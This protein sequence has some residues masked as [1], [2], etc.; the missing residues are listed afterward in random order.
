MTI[1]RKRKWEL[2]YLHARFK[3]LICNIS[4]KKTFLLI[5]KQNIAIKTK[6]IKARIDKTQQNSRYRLCADRDETNNRIVSE[7]SKLAQMAY[8]TRH[9]WVG[10]AIHW[11]LSKKF[12]FNHTNKWYMHN[13]ASVL[14]NETHKLLRDFDIQTDHLTTARRPDLIKINKKREFA[15]SW[16]LLSRMTTTSNWEKARRISTLTLLG[17]WKN[18]RTWKWRLYQL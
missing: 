12:R 3:R 6:H 7:Y 8:K 9:D 4:H 11:E 17:N 16:I 10:N 1:T 2:K 18:C 13:L 14:E 5:P 15:K